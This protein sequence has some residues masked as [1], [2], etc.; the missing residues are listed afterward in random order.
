MSKFV[1]LG[2]G[3]VCVVCSR[4]ICHES[5]QAT[6]VLAHMLNT[7][8]V[9]GSVMDQDLSAEMARLSVPASGKNE[10]LPSSNSKSKSAKTVTR[11][12]GASLNH[13]PK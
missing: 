4:H 6:L 2:K 9:T 12:S 5:L 8:T 13:S 10:F 1:P 11:N 7:Q 3:I